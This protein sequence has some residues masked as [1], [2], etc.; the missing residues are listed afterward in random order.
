MSGTSETPELRLWPWDEAAYQRIAEASGQDGELYVRFENGDEVH[1][2]VDRI[3]DLDSEADSVDWS[4]LTSDGFELTFSINGREVEIPWLQIRALSDEHLANHLAKRAEQEASFIGHQLRL[5]RRR[6]GLSSRQLAERAGMK[7]Q[8]LSRIERGRH[9]IGFSK[10]RL[11][12]AAM[13]YGLADLA[14]VQDAPVSADRIRRALAAAGLGDD[15]VE[16]LFFGADE[17][18]SML[19]RADRIFGW[20]ATDLAGP[21]APPQLAT[22]ALAGR[23]KGAVRDR[24]PVSAAYVTYAYYVA[25]LVERATER[26]AYTPP[27]EDPHLFAEAVR[28]R[29][30]DLSLASIVDYAWEHGIVVIALQDAGQFHGA[31]WLIEGTPVIVVKQGLA[32]NARWVFDLCHE[33]RHVLCHLSEDE[34]VVIELDAVGA[35]RADEEIEASEWAGFVLLGDPHGVAS[36]AAAAAGGRGEGLRH[37]LPRIAREEDVELGVLANY[38]ASRMSGQGLGNAMWGTAANLQKHEAATNALE[39]VLAALRERLDL[40]RLSDAQRLILEGALY[41]GDES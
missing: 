4:A 25:T 21:D 11:L 40:E 1:C 5:L 3:L 7:P 13:N 15:T 2:D 18:M 29:F 34:P 36:K 26:P 30:D 24:G 39:I 9:D 32:Y 37:V 8:A 28:E 19:G 14:A 33:I 27:P 41:G 22:P 20:S 31:C 10:V 16:R 23:F 17:P 12:L 38:I 35:S 6:R